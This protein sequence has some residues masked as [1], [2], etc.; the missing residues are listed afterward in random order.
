MSEIDNNIYKM[1]TNTEKYEFIYRPLD[2][3]H[4]NTWVLDDNITI[5]YNYNGLNKE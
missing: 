3:H 2:L 1:K 5:S 4:I